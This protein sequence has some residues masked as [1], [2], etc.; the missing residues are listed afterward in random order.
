MTI[1]ITP[2]QRHETVAFEPLMEQGAVSSCP[3]GFIDLLG[4]V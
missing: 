4:W 3:L 1:V 2:G